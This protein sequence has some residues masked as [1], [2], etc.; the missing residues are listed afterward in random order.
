MPDNTADVRL[1]RNRKSGSFERGLL[2]GMG[3][4]ESRDVGLDL[5]HG[6]AAVHLLTAGRT[7]TEPHSWHRVGLNM[8]L[9]G[10]LN[11]DS[12]LAH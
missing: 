7:F 11:D 2:G 4:H 8:K 12:V 10:P 6:L 1:A 3:F 9:A 5:S